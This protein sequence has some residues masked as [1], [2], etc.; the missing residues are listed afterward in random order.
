MEHIFL[1][2]INM[3]KLIILFLLLL[4]ENIFTQDHIQLLRN[5][6][7]CK[8]IFDHIASSEYKELY[9]SIYELLYGP[10]GLYK[11]ADA[12]KILHQLQDEYSYQTIRCIESYTYYGMEIIVYRVP[13]EMTN[14]YLAVIDITGTAQGYYFL[15]FDENY[16]FLDQCFFGSRRLQRKKIYE[17]KK[18]DGNNYGIFINVNGLY[19]EYNDLVT[20]DKD[21]FKI[22]P[23][24]SQNYE[25]RP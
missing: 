18:L 7:I 25:E 15:L 3:R 11:E 4:A 5:N 8:P 13:T 23:I 24:K 2:E 9:H 20:I 16:M 6:V 21:T 14:Y 22:V 12:F 19:G 1:G 10:N 17:F